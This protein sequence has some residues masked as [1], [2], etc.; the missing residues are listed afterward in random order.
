[1][2]AVQ[3][4]TA[5]SQ[6]LNWDIRCGLIWISTYED[7]QITG[8]NIFMPKLEKTI[9][10]TGKSSSFDIEAINKIFSTF[11]ENIR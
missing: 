11:E 10:E 5:N 8:W 2:V 3:S 1:V 6:I 9:D 7:L 4:C